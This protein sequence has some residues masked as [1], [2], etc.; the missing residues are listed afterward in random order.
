MVQLAIHPV[1]PTKLATS[2]HLVQATSLRPHLAT[3]PN[4]RLIHLSNQLGSKFVLA[5]LRSNVSIN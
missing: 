5:S 1:N 3:N 4:T 2:L